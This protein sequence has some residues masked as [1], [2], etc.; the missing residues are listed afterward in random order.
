MLLQHLAKSRSSTDFSYWCLVGNGWGMGVAGMIITSDYGSFPHSLR[1]APVSFFLESIESIV[2]SMMFILADGNLSYP[3]YHLWSRTNHCS[4]KSK[5][6][7]QPDWAWEKT[8]RISFPSIRMPVVPGIVGDRYPRYP[9]NTATLCSIPRPPCA[10]F[11]HQE[12]ASPAIDINYLK[13]LG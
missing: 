1:L 7:T 11:F 12:S 2:L 13:K 9:N 4:L 5:T 10:V 6:E 3:G 8:F